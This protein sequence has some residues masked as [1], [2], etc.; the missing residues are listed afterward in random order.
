MG[1]IDPQ[2]MASLYPRSL[3]GMIYRFPLSLRVSEKI[4]LSFSHQK[5]ERAIYLQGMAS[6]LY[7]MGLIGMIY[8]GTT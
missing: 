7:P 3:I 1:A 6:S 4:F 5:S 8:K 2:D